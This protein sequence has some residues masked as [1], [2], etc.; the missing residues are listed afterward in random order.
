M[1]ERAQPTRKYNHDEIRWLINDAPAELGARGVCMDPSGGGGSR[2]IADNWGQ[3]ERSHRSI[4]AVARYRRAMAVWTRLSIADQNTLAAYYTARRACPVPGAQAA[5]GD[6]AMV[7]LVITAD[8]PALERA[9]ANKDNAKHV[10]LVTA[11]RKAAEEAVRHAHAS[12]DVQARFTAI[13]RA[14]GDH[15]DRGVAVGA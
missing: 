5:F 9:V 10:P 3:I 11:T 6:L 13:Q 15:Q 8:R 7:A 2:V 12:W 14:N 1:S 4:P